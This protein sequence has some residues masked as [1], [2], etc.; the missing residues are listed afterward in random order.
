MPDGASACDGSV[1]LLSAEDDAADTI[2]PRLDALGADVSRV[3][4]LEAIRDSRGANVAL[5][6]QAIRCS[7]L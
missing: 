6:S 7:L 5:I 4:I 3:H 2:R 1:I